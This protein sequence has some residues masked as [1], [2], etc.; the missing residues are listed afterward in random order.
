M[1]S[2]VTLSPRMAI[3]RTDIPAGTGVGGTAFQYF[4]PANTFPSGAISPNATRSRRSYHQPPNHFVDARATTQDH[5]HRAGDARNSV[6]G[7]TCL[8]AVQS[9]AK[10]WYSSLVR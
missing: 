9:A 8:G 1:G 6:R 7:E 5:R 10:R 2:T 3:T 4:S